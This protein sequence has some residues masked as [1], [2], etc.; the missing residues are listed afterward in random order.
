MPVDSQIV[1]TLRSVLAGEPIYTFQLDDQHGMREIG[2]S[3]PSGHTV[4][5]AAK[6]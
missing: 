4:I 6:T 2:V 5:F 3:E 1:E